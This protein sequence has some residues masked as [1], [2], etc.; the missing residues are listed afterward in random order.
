MCLFI[1]AGCPYDPSDEKDYKLEKKSCACKYQE[2][3]NSSHAES[4]KIY[5]H[6]DF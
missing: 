6:R 5:N 1:Y 2:H 3:R 4:D